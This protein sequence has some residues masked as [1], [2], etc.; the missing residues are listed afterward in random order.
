M[1]ES[2]HVKRKLYIQKICEGLSDESYKTFIIFHLIYHSEIYT[3]NTEEN[4]LM[5]NWHMRKYI[6]PITVNKNSDP[7]TEFI[8]TC[9]TE[10]ALKT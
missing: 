6:Y 1:A 9:S 10:L 4:I 3:N 2:V 7:G 8:H 5:F